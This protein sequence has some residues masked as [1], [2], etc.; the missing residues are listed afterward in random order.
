MKKLFVAGCSVSDYTEVDEVYGEIIARMLGREYVH[1]GSGCGSNWRIWRRITNHIINGNLT[2]N[3]LLIVQYTTLERREFWSFNEKDEPNA[4]FRMRER[5]RN[6]LGGDIIKFKYCLYEHQNFPNEG[7][8]FE[9]IEKKFTNPYFD[10]DVFQTQHLMFQCL[11]KE[12]NIPT[13]FFGFYH[14]QDTIRLM[15]YFKD[16][17]FHVDE[18]KGDLNYLLKD[19]GHFNKNGHEYVAKR[20]AE[21]INSKNL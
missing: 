11:L 3:D 5:Y 21:F 19:L 7:K 18:I 6:P 1:E 2:P 8:L 4:K 14:N 15:D 16:S 20:M 13:I 17:Y 9:L 10:M 12:Y